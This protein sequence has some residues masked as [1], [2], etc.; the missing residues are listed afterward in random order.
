M[1]VIGGER[2]ELTRYNLGED[3]GVDTKCFSII[4]YLTINFYLLTSKR[5]PLVCVSV[6]LDIIVRECP[7]RVCY[8]TSSGGHV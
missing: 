6:V 5:K 7:C 2:G 3:N 1:V 4:G 8:K